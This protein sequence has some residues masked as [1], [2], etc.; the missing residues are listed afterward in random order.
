MG[1]RGKNTSANPNLSSLQNIWGA[2]INKNNI[3]GRKRLKS[4]ENKISQPLLRMSCSRMSTIQKELLSQQYHTCHSVFIHGV[5][6][7]ETQVFHFTHKAH[8]AFSS[9]IKDPWKPDSVSSQNGQIGL[10]N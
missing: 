4:Y 10:A 8:P 5:L 1:L 6:Q 9:L 7:M 2:K 3:L